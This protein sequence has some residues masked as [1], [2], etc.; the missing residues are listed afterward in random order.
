MT[1]NKRDLKI[2]VVYFHKDD[3]G[4]VY[5]VGVGTTKRPYTKDGRS[6]FWHRHTKKHCASGKP[7]IQIV[8]ENQD[9]LSACEHEKFWISA[10]G[11]RNNGTGVLVNLTDGGEGVTGMIHSEE[12]RLKNSL[13]KKGKPG[14]SYSHTDESKLKMSVAKKGR[15]QNPE[16]IAKMVE[17]QKQLRANPDYI[18]PRKGRKQ[19]PEHIA[20]SLIS[21]TITINQSDYIDPRIGR[22]ASDETRAKLV[23]SQRLRRASE[24]QQKESETTI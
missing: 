14:R 5:Y 19:S 15:K 10:Y 16:S 1:E 8:Y 11:R 13:S 23:I 12:S 20:K 4:K 24:Q 2:Y 21:R 6:G 9:W 17:T 3:S 7:Q 18:D 22:T